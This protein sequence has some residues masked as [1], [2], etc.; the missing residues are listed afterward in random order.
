MAAVDVP[1]TLE[2]LLLH[3]PS[4]PLALPGTLGLVCCIQTLVESLDSFVEE[5]RGLKGHTAAGKGTGLVELAVC[6]DGRLDLPDR[7]SW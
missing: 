3:L 4:V 5:P 1:L 6:P 7:E 2:A